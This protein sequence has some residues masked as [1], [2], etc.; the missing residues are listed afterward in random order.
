MRFLLWRK[1]VRS[2]LFKSS[3]LRIYRGKKSQQQICAVSCQASMRRRI[4]NSF[5]FFLL[6]DRRCVPS[7]GSH[8]NNIVHGWLHTSCTADLS[9]SPQGEEGGERGEL[10]D[11]V[12]AE[13]M[14][15]R[16]ISPPSLSCYGEQEW[17]SGS[18]SE[19]L[20]SMFSKCKGFVLAFGAEQLKSTLRISINRKKENY[21]VTICRFKRCTFFVKL[22]C[23]I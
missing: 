2:A 4:D 22:T 21:I 15:D 9:C 17:F 18:Q 13:Q 19:L 11:R 8:D 6:T 1:L 23:C 14:W 5:F 16:F 7:F 12:T 20:S 3:T 10:C